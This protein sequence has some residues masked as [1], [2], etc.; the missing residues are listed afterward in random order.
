[1]KRWDVPDNRWWEDPPPT[2]RPQATQLRIAGCLVGSRVVLVLI[3]GGIMLLCLLDPS[4]VTPR[5][6]GSVFVLVLLIVITGSA[7]STTLGD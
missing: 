3:F 7:L 4:W 1:M 5:S 6:R 2:P